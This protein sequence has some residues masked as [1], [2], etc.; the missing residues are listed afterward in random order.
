M[1]NSHVKYMRSLRTPK[2]QTKLQ[3]PHQLDMEKRILQ[4]IIRD[5][6]YPNLYLWAMNEK[7]STHQKDYLLVQ[8]NMVA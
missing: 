5:G 1:R 8:M 2:Y 6:S 7:I 4:V 3:K